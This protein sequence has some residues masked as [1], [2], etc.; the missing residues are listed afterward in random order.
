VE[1][2]GEFTRRK[3]EVKSRKKEKRGGDIIIF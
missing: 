3:L 1:G 2:R